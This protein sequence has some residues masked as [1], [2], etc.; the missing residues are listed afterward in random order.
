MDIAEALRR[1]IQGGRVVTFIRHAYAEHLSPLNSSKMRRIF[2]HHENPFGYEY[3]VTE[4]H[5]KHTNF[6]SFIVNKCGVDPS[7][8]PDVFMGVVFRG[9]MLEAFRGDHV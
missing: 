5:R 8:F 4:T 9:T 3:V 1:R 7:K 2:G 6:N